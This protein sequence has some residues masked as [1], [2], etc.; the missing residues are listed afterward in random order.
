[1]ADKRL[2]Y[3]EAELEKAFEDGDLGGDS[4]GGRALSVFYRWLA[5]ER[6]LERSERDAAMVGYCTSKV[7]ETMETAVRLLRE[8]DCPSGQQP[9]P[10]PD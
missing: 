10:W 6:K 8:L 5:S 9:P 3:W 1:M 4:Y 2:K 7:L